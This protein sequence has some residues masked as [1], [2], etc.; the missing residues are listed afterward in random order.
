MEKDVLQGLFGE[1]CRA[2]PESRVL[3]VSS[4]DQVTVIV[5]GDGGWYPVEGVSRAEIREGY[6]VLADEEGT[7]HFVD[8][9]RIMAVR[10]R[11]SKRDGAGFR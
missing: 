6:V 9:A 3:K 2:K 11:S 7:S 4:H 5:A 10:V 1:V 8:A